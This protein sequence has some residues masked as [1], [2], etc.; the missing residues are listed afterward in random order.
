MATSM[1]SAEATVD[2]H[3]HLTDRFERGG[4][5]NPW[6]AGTEGLQQDF[7]ESALAACRERE[8]LGA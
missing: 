5:A 7:P 3:I 8:G 6:V 4:L 1:V 2:A